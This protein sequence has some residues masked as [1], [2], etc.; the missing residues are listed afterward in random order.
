MSRRITWIPPLL[1][2]LAATLSA[3][4]APAQYAV[5]HR[6]FGVGATFGIGYTKMDYQFPGVDE[7]QLFYLL[8]TL[9]L[10]IFFKDT[11]SL[12][13]NI[14]V[15]NIAASNALQDYFF[16]TG[17]VYLN[18]H[19]SAPSGWE[20]FAAP[21]F[22]IS[23]ASWKDEDLDLSENGYAF[24]IPVRLGMEFNNQRRNLSLFIAVR[25]FFSLVH[26]AGE[27]SPGGGGMLEIGL[28]AYTTRYRADR[29]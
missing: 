6:T 8:P 12:D 1:F 13:L 2:F 7:G 27:N 9:E 16:V 11:L 19:P 22:G 17:D 29:Y 3:G 21:G 24:H 15:V 14:P 20:L 4:S 25:P 28:M 5:G 26:G 10:K 18:F 23:Y